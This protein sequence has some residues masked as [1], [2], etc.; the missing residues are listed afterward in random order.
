MGI[1]C[2]PVWHHNGMRSSQAFSM[3]LRGTVGCHQ[4]LWYTISFKFTR[5]SVLSVFSVC[6]CLPQTVG[7]GYPGWKAVL[8]IV[9]SFCARQCFCWQSGSWECSDSL[10]LGIGWE[11]HLFARTLCL[12]YLSQYEY[13]QSIMQIWTPKHW[14]SKTLR[15]DQRPW[16]S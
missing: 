10:F 14:V 15:E 1:V 3:T 8:S 5:K 4:R 12:L 16:E 11:S 2:R 6:V 13:I 7:E 9:R